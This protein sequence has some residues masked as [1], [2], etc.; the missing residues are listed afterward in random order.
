MTSV[1]EYKPGQFYERELPC[2]QTLLEKFELKPHCIVVDS[3]VFLDGVQRPGLGKYVYDALDGKVAIIG[4][5]KTSFDG[6]GE[7][8]QIHRGQSVKPLFITC[9]GIELELAKAHILSMYGKHRIPTLLKAA[10]QLCRYQ[11]IQ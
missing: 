4:V 10:D 11:K 7:Q 5:A 3:Y 6:I 2:I 1:A 9:A 8:F